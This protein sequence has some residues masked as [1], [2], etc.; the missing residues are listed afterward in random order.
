M[1]GPELFS[2]SWTPARLGLSSR[3][4]RRRSVAG[5]LWGVLLD[6]TGERVGP[7]P[8]TAPATGFEHHDPSGSPLIARAAC[9][10]EQARAVIVE[11]HAWRRSG[12]AQANNTAVNEP[13]A[14]R[15]CFTCH[16]GW[17]GA[18]LSGGSAAVPLADCGPAPGHPGRA[19]QPELSGADQRSSALHGRCGAERPEG[20][21]RRA[22]LVLRRR[23]HL[24]LPHSLLR[25]TLAAEA[26]LRARPARLQPGRSQRG[27]LL[28][29]RPA[30]APSHADHVNPR[31]RVGHLDDHAVL[32]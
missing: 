20:P 8:S 12:T 4:G 10:G 15:V 9:T 11:L 29:G 14:S 18:A 17:S 27:R 2:W 24:E 25:F 23:H 19:D 30:G 6:Q 26:H 3:S 32:G 7:R 21:A 16:R 28:F 31:F 22:V 13:N 1:E 5:T